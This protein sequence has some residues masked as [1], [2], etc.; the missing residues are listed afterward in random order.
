[1]RAL[2][3]CGCVVLPL[4]ERVL[5]RLGGS[6]LIFPGCTRCLGGSAPVPRL[7]LLDWT[8]FTVLTSAAS[9]A[10]VRVC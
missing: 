3:M 1:M 5:A 9:K 8:G 2:T 7:S 10:L 4:F 6:V